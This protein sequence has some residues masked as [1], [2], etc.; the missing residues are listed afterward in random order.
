MILPLVAVFGVGAIA[1][2]VVAQSAGKAWV[3][4]V[5]FL[6]TLIA[7]NET[8][9]VLRPAQEWVR[10]DLVL[11]VPVFALINLALARRAFVDEHVMTAL[12]LTCTVAGGPLAIHFAH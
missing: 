6:N 10:L 3:W 11:I 12:V 9:Y 5:A 8:S 2:L 1:S 4:V 7:F